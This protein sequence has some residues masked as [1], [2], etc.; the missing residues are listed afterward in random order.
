M[1]SLAL[2]APLSYGPH[3]I[4]SMSMSIRL[5]VP[6][7]AR[8]GWCCVGR[9]ELSVA[10]ELCPDVPRAAGVVVMSARVAETEGQR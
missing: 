4:S 2:R 8:E 7:P 9:G 10:K 3:N 6:E 1:G 5:V